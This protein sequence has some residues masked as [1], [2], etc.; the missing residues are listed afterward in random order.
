LT[1]NKAALSD[2]SLS[3]NMLAAA[4]ATTAVNVLEG[5]NLKPGNRLRY[6]MRQQ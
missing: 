2:E 1:Y 3:Q 6:S 5:R 4:P